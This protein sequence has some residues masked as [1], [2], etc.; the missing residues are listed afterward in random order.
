M[1]VGELVAWLELR[2][3][4]WASGLASARRDL[5]G[6]R[7]DID[8]SSRDIETF[9]NA[10]SA[11][12]KPT[13]L[14]A[15]AGSA[16][17]LSSAVIPAA[18]ALWLL[19]AP[20]AAAGA[21]AA[22]TKV[23]MV[24][25]GDAMKAIAKGD[26]KKLADAMR[27][28]SP[29]GRSFVTTLDQI[30]KKFLT[31]RQS[32]QEKLF[33]G[34]DR[35]LDGL[36]NNYLPLLDAGMGKTATSLNGLARAGSQVMQS[37]FMKGVAAL[38][39][40]ETARS[41]DAFQP[42]IGP[43]VTALGMLLKVGMPLVTQFS[44]WAAG[45][46]QAKAGFLSSAAGADYLRA[47]IT[48]G[49]AVLQQL[50]SIA[51][52]VSRAVSNI[53]T[54]GN[55][56]GQ[57]LLTTL[58]NVTAKF[59]AWTATA[60]GQAQINQL[61]TALV[62]IAKSMAIIIPVFAGALA[63]VA[64]VF[65]SLP[66]PV[67]SVIAAF[68]SWGLII[69]L[70]VSKFA[71]LFALLG[72]IGPV[73]VKA[74]GKWGLLGAAARTAASVTG[75]GAASILGAFGRMAAGVLARAAMIA[76]GWLI[77]MGP[78]GWAIAAVVGI[79]ALVIANWDKV[80]AF[81]ISA[82]TAVSS[83][84]SSA[85]TAVVGWVTGL[86]GRIMGA[87]TALGSMIATGAATAWNWLVT[88]AQT[89]V[90]N[91]VTFLTQLPMQVAYALG[92]LAGMVY[93]GALAAWNFLWNTLPGVLA[94]VG[95]WLAGLPARV[96][97]WLSA[98]ASTV[99]TKAGE[100]WQWLVTKV[101]EFGEQAL[102]WIQALPGKVG[103]FLASL[104]GIVIGAATSAFTG[105]LN[106]I[107]AGG[108]AALA[109]VQAIPGKV[110]GFFSAAGS[111]LVS[112]GSAIIEGLW[113]GLK[114]RAQAVLDWIADLGRRIAAGFKAAIS[115]RSPSKVFDKIADK[116]IGGGLLQGLDRMAPGVLAKMRGIAQDTSR[117]ASQ[118]M[119]AAIDG[120]LAGARSR[121]NDVLDQARSAGVTINIHNPTAERSSA[122]IN[123][124]AHTQ[125]LLGAF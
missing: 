54:A 114:A 111:W 106:A 39:F 1:T 30:N 90:T 25:M 88:T 19:P 96:G 79:A 84:V 80:K 10:L 31:V 26:A 48:T 29:A 4:G 119:G 8:R 122:S 109:W 32:V 71:P 6:F 60:Q 101:T 36:A 100:A 62:D 64:G 112:A 5:E 52:N 24:G 51:G 34:L 59:A 9:G 68:L 17:A 110:M 50:G 63:T 87:L 94:Q 49:I 86:P 102:A 72:R 18:G 76:A 78:V 83:A 57:S 53:F 61:L 74:A 118:N 14:V 12:S 73:I 37:P 115:S 93:N 3:R 103:S 20:I 108:S 45:A 65:A 23:G 7:T 81:T 107:I 95:T 22:T 104:P 82:W 69:G 123:Q 70:V 120:R 46:L 43:A 41:L 66:A 92:Y 28:M 11:V 97:A 125:A 15:L 77:A 16:V 116:G 98:L 55:I 13:G 40:T 2:S 91:V 33:G 113:N 44:Q 42:A 38:V 58:E 99:S 89:A 67:Q 75:A 56:S 27:D 85:V 105:F 35:E 117:A 21:V 47:K 121:I 124:A